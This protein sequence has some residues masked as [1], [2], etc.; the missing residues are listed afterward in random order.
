[1]YLLALFETLKEHKLTSIKLGDKSLMDKIL[2]YWLTWLT[3]HK[4][5]KEKEKKFKIK[6]NIRKIN[7]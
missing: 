2:I 6:T 1:M 5:A 4:H 7:V 3:Y